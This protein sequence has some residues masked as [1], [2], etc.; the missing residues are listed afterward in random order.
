[1]DEC[2]PGAPLEVAE[3]SADRYA[4]FSHAA[5]AYKLRLQIL[6]NDEEHR[7]GFDNGTDFR[8]GDEMFT[9]RQLQRK[10]MKSQG[11][12]RKHKTQNKFR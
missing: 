2:D 10:H 5:F 12:V 7:E 4:D 1:M 6:P 11:I 9:S 3:A 8:I